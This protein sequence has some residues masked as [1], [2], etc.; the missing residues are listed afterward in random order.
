MN[1]IIHNNNEYKYINYYSNNKDS[2]G[3]KFP[4]FKS[5]QKPISNQSTFLN[6][7][8]SLENL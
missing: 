7:L 3:K 2:N 8:K 5:L 4:Q 6:N 1:T